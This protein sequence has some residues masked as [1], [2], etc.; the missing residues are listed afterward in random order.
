MTHPRSPV[1]DLELAI[2]G[3]PYRIAPEREVEMGEWI[4]ANGLEMEVCDGGGFNFKVDLKSKLI[5]TNVA[6]L[7]YLWASAYAYLT[8]YNE[9]GLAQQRGEGQFDTGWNKR[10]RDCLD[11]LR[12]SVGN[13]HGSGTEKWPEDLPRPTKNP[14][15]QT[16][17][18][19]ANEMFLCAFAWIVH[20]ELAHVR[21]GHQPVLKT[22]TIYEERDADV[23]ATKF[24]LEKCE[25]P[26]PRRKRSLGV[27]VALLAIQSIETKPGPGQLQTHPHAFERI[28]YCMTESGLSDDD[29]V[30]ALCACVMQ[31]QLASRGYAVAHDGDSFRSI[32]DSYLLEFKRQ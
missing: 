18:N 32:L 6:T 29:E 21:L 22:D 8:L 11:L 26:E 5:R 15:P 19:N 17:G 9:Y 2:A 7:E 3:A 30:F 16:D 31:I 23:S 25:E 12:W 24:I 20:H 27:A 14:E 4:E 13:L 1:L 10:C 28:D